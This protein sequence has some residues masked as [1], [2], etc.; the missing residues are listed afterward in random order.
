MED[1]TTNVGA[2]APSANNQQPPDSFL[3]WSILATILCCLPFGIAAIVNS[4]RVESRWYAGDYE[5][6]RR[7]ASNARMWFWWAFGVGLFIGV[8]YGIFI[9][10]LGLG[11]DLF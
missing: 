2:N 8:V 9:A 5:G 3:V 4:S 7:A 6:A 1:T 10:V 11:G